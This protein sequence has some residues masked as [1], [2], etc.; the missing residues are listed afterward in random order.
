[1]DARGFLRA[2]YI[3]GDVDMIVLAFW[4][5]ETTPVVMCN[6]DIVIDTDKFKSFT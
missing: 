3:A 4:L 6:E 2:A 1:M 5:L